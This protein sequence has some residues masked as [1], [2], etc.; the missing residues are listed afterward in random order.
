[1]GHK[2]VNIAEFVSPICYRVIVR[3]LG[4]LTTGILFG[5]Q[6]GYNTITQVFLTQ[7]S[8]LPG[9][10]IIVTSAVFLLNPG[11]KY[12]RPFA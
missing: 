5:S 3:Q 8:V 12:K 7:P 4:S 9:M 10:A 1:M 11:H 2:V 6:L